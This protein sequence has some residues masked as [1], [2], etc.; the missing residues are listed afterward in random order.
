MTQSV[1]F[2]EPFADLCEPLGGK[3]FIECISKVHMHFLK[4]PVFFFVLL[5]ARL[6]HCA[7]QNLSLAKLISTRQSAL[8][9][10]F[11]VAWLQ[12]FTFVLWAAARFLL[13]SSFFAIT[14]SIF[15]YR[16]FGRV[17]GLISSATGL[18]G[19]L[20]LPLTDLAIKGLQ[21][22]FLP[23]QIGSAVAVTAMYVPALVIYRDERAD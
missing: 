17:V 13:Y 16:S 2:N 19:L 11:E 5:A 14:G 6:K 8:K 7:L 4:R 9:T 20:Q 15:T 1:N 18:V 23:L 22:N 3:R 12:V 10:Y 21:R